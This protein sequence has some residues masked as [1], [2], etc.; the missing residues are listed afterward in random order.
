MLD[1]TVSRGNF[2]KCW[3]HDM[4]RRCLGYVAMAV[5][6]LPISRGTTARA[7]SRLNDKDLARLMQ[8]VRDDA[9]PFRHSFANALKKSTIRGTSREKDARGLA[10]TFAKQA[11]RAL[12]TFRHRRKAESE[13]SA[14]VSTAGQIDPLVYSLK[15]NATV[16]SHWEKLRT[17]LHEVARA[18]GVREPYFQSPGQSQSGTAGSGVETSCLIS[19]GGKRSAVLVN[20]C[21]QVS[22]ATHP[23]CN[24]ENA[25]ALIVNEI[26]RGC[27]ML[28]QDAPGFCAEYK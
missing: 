26:R 27:G 1:C 15:L 11:Q 16:T 14:M 7:Q 21:L 22:P 3:R 8:N 18:F 20:E 24:A 4:M 23:P 12:E 28:G 19:V 25:C 9:E 2:W 6:L 10:D 5:F 13:V 17:E